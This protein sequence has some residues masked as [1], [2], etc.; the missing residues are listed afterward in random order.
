MY[1]LYASH[2]IIVCVHKTVY[3]RYTI[4]NHNNNNDTKQKREAM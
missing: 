3:S 1:S 4:Q 2:P